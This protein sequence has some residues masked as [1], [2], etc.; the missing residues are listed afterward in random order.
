MERCIEL[1]NLALYSADGLSEAYFEADEYS[2]E[3]KGKFER[4]QLLKKKEKL[5][6]DERAERARLRL[7]LKNIPRGLSPEAYERFEAIEGR[8]L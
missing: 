5:T 8:G 4:Y 2:E 1:E 6:E 7:E 3:L